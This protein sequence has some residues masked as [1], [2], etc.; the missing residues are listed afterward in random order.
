MQ[1][2]LCFVQCVKHVFTLISSIY[3]HW[4]IKLINWKFTLHF[5]FLAQ[6]LGYIKRCALKCDIIYRAHIF[7]TWPTFAFN[8]RLCSK[9]QCVVGMNQLITGKSRNLGFKHVQKP[10]YSEF[11]LQSLIYCGIIIICRCQCSWV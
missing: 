5:I 9:N 2:S 4:Q 1:F 8:N 7:A 10:V 6:R 3:L 11:S